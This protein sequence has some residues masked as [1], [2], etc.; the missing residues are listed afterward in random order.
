MKY[1]GPW[2]FGQLN[3]PDLRDQQKEIPFDVVLMPRQ[4]D[5]SRPH[6]GWAE[7]VAI[8]QTD[9]I[10]AAWDFVHFM[11]GEEGDKLYSEITGRIPNSLE[12]IESFWVPTIKERFGV[13]NGQAFVEAFKLSEFDVVGGVSRTK[14]WTEVVKPVG[15]DPLLG[16][17]ATA[18]EVMPKV[19][20]GAQ[21]ILDDYWATVG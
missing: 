20:E 18:A 17:S 1:E 9:Q 7:G 3:S 2:F 11:A 21:Q 13:E 19:N 12:L 6:R 5:D 8:P 10:E 14:V 16:N 4:Q 15:Y